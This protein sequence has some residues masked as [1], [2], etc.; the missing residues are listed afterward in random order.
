MKVLHVSSAELYGGIET[1]LVSLA[2]HRALCPGLDQH[3]ALCFEGRLSEELH[4][5][6]VPVYMLGNVRL[7]NPLSIRRARR[8]LDSVI[9]RCNFDV[10]ICH[11]PRTMV[12]FSKTVRG[13]QKPL[14]MWMHGIRVLKR[15]LNHLLGRNLPDLMICNSLYTQEAV[16][17]VFPGIES[18]VIYYPLETASTVP[19]ARQR[20]AV[21][22]SWGV[23][24]DTA[25]IVLA[26]RMVPWKGHQVL[27]DALMELGTETPWQCWIVGGPQTPAEQEYFSTL[28]SNVLSVGLAD[29]IRFLGQRSDVAKILPAADVFCQPN[30][31]G[32]PFG[33]VYIEAMQAGLP[34]LT[35]A[36]GAAVEIVDETSGILVPPDD[37]TALAQALCNLLDDP[38]VL[39]RL[40]AGGPAR[41]RLLCDPASRLHALQDLLETAQ[42]P[43]RE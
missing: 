10:I 39:R 22:K 31:E 36:M 19:G 12:F 3:F 15:W 35:S 32:E 41:A 33:V 23:N 16:A 40:S 20:N 21:R 30:L 18:T 6:D 28:E 43:S 38:V 8:M 29:R 24:E 1:V 5:L 11:G 9:K 2:R 13:A 7:K 34:V 26:S 14:L 17:S 37:P 4:A 42:S 25:V 27:V